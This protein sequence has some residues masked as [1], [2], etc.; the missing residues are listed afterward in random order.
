M[1]SLDEVLRGFGVEQSVVKNADN[2]NTPLEQYVKEASDV[3]I[4][5]MSNHIDESNATAN[6]QLKQSLLPPERSFSGGNIDMEFSSSAKYALWRNDGV[7]GRERLR[8]TEYQYKATHPSLAMVNDIE[9]WM[10]A[11]G[12]EA[13]GWAIASNVLKFGFDGARFIEAAFSQE[14]LNKFENDILIVVENT[15]IGM[16]TKVI[17]EFK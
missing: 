16:F 6:G 15:V 13:S 5:L 10:V 1:A 17:P 2:L 7:S 11:K 9:Q 3:F 8:E 12:I 14:N 4:Q